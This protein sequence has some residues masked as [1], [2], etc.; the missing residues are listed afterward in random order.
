MQINFD[1]SLRRLLISEG[2]YTNHPSD[3]GGPTNY[4]ITIYDARKYAAEFGWI[5]GR[6]VTTQD[7]KDMPLW[8]AKKVYDAKYWHS[9]L[10]HLLASGVDYAIF[11]Y[12]VNS[13]IGRS[14]KVLKRVLGMDASSSVVTPDVVAAV[15]RV[16]AVKVIN[17]VMDERLHFLQALNTWPV[18]GA[19]WGRRVVEVRAASLHMAQ[20][21][22]FVT[23][24]SITPESGSE[25]GTIAPPDKLK[26]VIVAGGSG[27]GGGVGATF[28]QWVQTHPVEAGALALGGVV[29]VGGAVYAVNKWHKHRTEAP[30][31]GWVS[32]NLLQ[33]AA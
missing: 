24:P 11:D 22:P 32:P 6:A 27:S 28:W 3:P 17:A 33:Q 16:G 4:G 18:F 10:C 30:A 19:G 23:A 8:F 20:A 9:Q 26:K 1:E 25:K 31:P 15:E 5:V 7:I 12:G 2:G 13:G 29:I 14:G 21:A